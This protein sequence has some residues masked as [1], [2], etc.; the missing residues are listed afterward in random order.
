LERVL[1]HAS[2]GEFD[3]LHFHCDYL[4]YPFARRIPVPHVTTLHGRLD[5]PDL[6]PLYQEYRE[7]PLVSIS[8]S[9]RAPLPWAN[10]QDTVYHGLPQ[11]LYEP[12][13]GGE[14]YLAFVGRTSPEKGLERAI[15][16]ALRVQIELRIAAKVDPSDSQY[17]CE[18]IRPLLND[19]LIKFVGEIGETEKNEFFGN[20]IAALFPVNWPE[21]FGLVMIEALACGTPVI[22]W[23]SGS[24]P[25]IID[26][27]V[28]G[29][30]VN[31]VEEAVKA[32]E[33]ID[34][35]SRVRCRECFEQ[36]FPIELMTR[37]YLTVYEKLRGT[38]IK[39][40]T[41]TDRRGR[42]HPGEGTVL[43]PLD[44]LTG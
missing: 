34:C 8:D 38:A 25:E 4:H 9:Q 14:R 44:L 11:D 18:V 26:Q 40:K 22:A 37:N 5:I 19:P 33:T 17:F 28:S 41:A 3:I 43:H 31:S 21:P 20:A 16:V 15:E 39:Q 30:V 1:D 27:G 12:R 35:I 29:F 32:V 23:R 6:F 2:R 7:I 36:R 24:V 10:W 42:H 13:L